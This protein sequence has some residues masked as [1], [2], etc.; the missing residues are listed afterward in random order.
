MWDSLL[1]ILPSFL[2]SFLH[3]RQD[4]THTYWALHAHGG[5]RWSYAGRVMVA[6]AANCV[7]LAVRSVAVHSL[8]GDGGMVAHHSYT[9][10]MPCGTVCCTSAVAHQQLPM[11]LLAV[12][13]DPPPPT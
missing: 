11:L 2:A 5:Q 13:F 6:S 10:S 3:H 7:L 8:L 1:G 4:V 12:L 9:S